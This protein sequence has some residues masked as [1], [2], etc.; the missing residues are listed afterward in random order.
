[1]AFKDLTLLNFKFNFESSIPALIWLKHLL[2]WLIL[3]KAL[4]AKKSGKSFILK[5][6]WIQSI[7]IDDHSFISLNFPNPTQTLNI[8]KHRAYSDIFQNKN[9]MTIF[10]W[11]WIGQFERRPE[12]WW[13]SISRFEH[14]LERLA[15]SLVTAL[16]R[17]FMISMIFSSIFC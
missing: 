8:I 13:P 12:R 6:F 1:M 17:L 4:V 5:S 10:V 9:K 7:L 11:S 2:Q 14:E 3:P 15:F 16:N